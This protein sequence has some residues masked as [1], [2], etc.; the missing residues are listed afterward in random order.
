MSLANCRLCRA[1]SSRRYVPSSPS[2]LQPTTAKASLEVALDRPER[3]GRQVLTTVHGH[4]CPASARLA[5][6]SHVTPLLTDWP[7]LTARLSDLSEDELA[8]HT[9]TAVD[10]ISLLSPTFAS[11]KI[12][13]WPIRNYTTGSSVKA[14][15]H[16]RFENDIA[17]TCP[18][19]RSRRGLEE[20]SAPDLRKTRCDHPPQRSGSDRPIPRRTCVSRQRPRAP[21]GSGQPVGPPCPLTRNRDRVEF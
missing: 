14:G 9:S 19:E 18:A 3:S 4:R 13:A 17:V 10:S 6:D 16:V 15:R 11:T 12:D 5:F 7:R 20:K 8:G 2:P 1:E 21:R